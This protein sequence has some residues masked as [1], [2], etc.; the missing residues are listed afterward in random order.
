MGETTCFILLLTI[1]KPTMAQKKTT[2]CK[3]INNKRMMSKTKCQGLVRGKREIE[4]KKIRRG[5]STV[6][7]QQV[8]VH[9]PHWTSNPVRDK[10]V[11]WIGA[12]TLRQTKGAPS[13]TTKCKLQRAPPPLHATIGH[14]RRKG[15]RHVFTFYN[16]VRKNCVDNPLLPLPAIVCSAFLLKLE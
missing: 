10:T 7:I 14:P 6:T 11:L 1:C 15:K 4:S 2:L 16:T 5:I 12:E 9:S 3:N 13:L 8:W